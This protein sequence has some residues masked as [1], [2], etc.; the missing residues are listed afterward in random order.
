MNKQ[1]LLS[2]I[3]KYHLN[4]IVEGVR[5]NVKDK[6]INIA[7]NAPNKDMMGFIKASDF[8]LEDCEIAIY[9]TS[10]LYKLLNITEQN[11]LLSLHREQTTATKLLIADTE[12][13]LEY[14]LANN[15]MVSKGGTVNDVEFEYSFKLDKEFIDK[16]IKAKKSVA[17]ELLSISADNKQVTFILGENNNY[18]N[19]VEFFTPT[20]YESKLT[21]LFFNADYVREIFDCNREITSGECKV[22]KDG[23]MEISIIDEKNI[24]SK[25]YLIA[26]EI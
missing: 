7:F 23:L 3:D 18:S 25:Y 10:T 16:Y 1:Y 2:I 13:N 21:P 12:Y 20:D 4:G 15:M 9:I 19:K 24:E 14:V 17:T 6:V 26:K 22:C 11:L 8:E 5:W